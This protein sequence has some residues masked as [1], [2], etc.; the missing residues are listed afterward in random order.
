VVEGDMFCSINQAVKASA[1]FDHTI[2]AKAEMLLFK[3]LLI[4]T[5]RNES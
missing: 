1:N 2:Q 5:L 4:L 3:S